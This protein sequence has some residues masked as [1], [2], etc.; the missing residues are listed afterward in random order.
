MPL[1]NI[2]FWLLVGLIIGWSLHAWQNSEKE[3]PAAPV[4][5]EKPAPAD[6][7]GQ[8]IADGDTAD[9]GASFQ[10]HLARGEVPQALLMYRETRSSDPVRAAAMR[11]AL[12]NRAR[13]LMAQKKPDQAAPLLSGYL[14]IESYDPGALLLR[15]RLDAQRE[16]YEQALE[17]ALD[18]KIYDRENTVTESADQVIGQITKAWRAQLTQK[19]QWH[20]L[21]EMYH[22]LIEKDGDRPEY[23][24]EL[25]G[26]QYRAGRY[27]E[28]LGSLNRILH[29]P[30]WGGKARKLSRLVEQLRQLGEGAPIELTRAGN[31]FLIEANV[32]DRRAD[33]VLDTGASI[34]IVRRRFADA[35]GL[36]T[37]GGEKTRFNAVGSQVEVT[38]VNARSFRVGDV[39]FEDMPIGIAEMPETFDADGLLGMDFLGNFEFS[40]DQDN[41]VLN[42]KAP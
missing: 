39:T 8:T 20:K 35:V 13:R 10:A 1:L 17:N 23:Y 18:G 32:N 34:S 30:E 29:D 25:A 37:E 6:A 36:S 12:L 31:G 24:Y 28:G 14:E 19:K 38:I 27:Y 5:A 40:I 26:A 22:L 15:A 41:E 3:P 2:T 9:E 33:L 21:G 16:R 7:P 4:L 42:L 11:T